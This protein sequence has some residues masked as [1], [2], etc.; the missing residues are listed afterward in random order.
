VVPQARGPVRPS[1]AS[2]RSQPSRKPK[3]KRGKR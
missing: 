2:G 3:S 1:T